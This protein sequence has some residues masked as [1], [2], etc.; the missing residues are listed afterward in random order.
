MVNVRKDLTG[1][2]FGRLTVVSQT[3]DYININGEHFSC[4][5]CLCDC[6]NF[7]NVRGGYLT[8]KRVQSC[9]CLLHE[10]AKNKKYNKYD[11]S[12]EYG[13]GWTSNTNEEF[14]F[15]LEDYDKIKN[16]YWC[17]HK[18]NKDNYFRLEGYDGEKVVIF[19]SVIGCKNYDHID[20]NTFNNCKSNLRPATKANNAQ[21]RSISSINT[22]GVT[23]VTYK[24]SE[25]IWIA[26]IG[27]QGKRLFLACSKNKTIAIKARLKAEKELYGEFAPQKHLFEQY[28]I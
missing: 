24:E 28:G 8:N 25:E 7:K 23:G 13:V 26:R 20:R 17:K 5:E 21:N 16:I 12:G 11:L 1:M 18:S 2:R 9:G 10:P 15:D 14:Y 4:W 22:S 27:F 3:Q 6:G 19:T